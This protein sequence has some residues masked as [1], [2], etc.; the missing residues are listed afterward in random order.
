[1]PPLAI[2]STL[3]DSLTA[4]LDRLG[5]AR[6]VAQL[7]STIGR[8]FSYDLLRTISSMGDSTLQKALAALVE[9]EVLYRRGVTPQTRYFFK[10]AL[11]RDAA[12]ESLLKSRRQQI[13]SSIA[14]ALEEYFPDIASA[15]PE[16]LAHHYRAA[17]LWAQSIPY[18][19]NAGEQAL[20]RCAYLE[21][22]TH[23]TTALDLLPKEVAPTELEPRQEENEKTRCTLLLAIGEAQRRNGQPLEAEQ[24]I[25]RATDVAQALLST[26]LVSRAAME[27]TSLAF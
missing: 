18:W 8:D 26:E 3:Q 12:Y 7:A 20:Q 9:A 27:L 14:C 25:V 22:I 16:L 4:R 10:H 17:G 2:P 5:R 21:S 24:T 11:I 13:H 15:Q 19:R 23:F 6:E 1:L